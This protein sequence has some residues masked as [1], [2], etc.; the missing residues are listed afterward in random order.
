MTVKIAGVTFDCREA[1]LARLVELGE[2][3]LARAL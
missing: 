1:E 3:D 2:F